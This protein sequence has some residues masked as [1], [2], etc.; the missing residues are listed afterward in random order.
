MYYQTKNPH[1]GD[2]YGEAVE[3]DYSANTN[4]L[5][6]PPAVIAAAA[7]A[8][9]RADRYPDPYCRALVKAIAAAE[10]VPAGSILCGNGA[11]GL[12]FSFCAAAKIRKAAAL[13]PTFSEYA[14]AVKLF[15]GETVLY[16]LCQDRGFLPD[17]DFPDWLR[18][19]R[20]D[21]VFLCNPNNPT[22][23]LLPPALI[24]EVI[25]LCKQI[26][27]RLFVDECFLE[28]ASGGE[29][30]KGCLADFPGLFLLR[31]FTK[32]YGM[33][34]LRLGYC[35][36]ADKALLGRMAALTPPW[37]VSAPAQAAGA[38]ALGEGG[39][40]R[41]AVSLIERERP[42]LRAALEAMG[43]WVCPSDVN[44][45]LFRGPESLLGDLRKKGIALRDCAN[46]PGLGPGWYRMAVR[47]EEEN[48]RLLAAMK[49]C[50]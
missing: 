33:A 19:E 7:E 23:R 6:V 40:L 20:P 45:L 12:I 29:S 28:L 4:P 38:A 16:P 43:L 24:I 21:A 9:T 49:E 15:G 39:F 31:A 2:I 35:L 18:A 50:L 47:T 22:G 41:K 46:F 32:S 3:L 30:L 11:S 17:E 26:N 14:A 48:D 8:L 36:S 25:T 1:G 27:T 10:E 13:A 37:D 42:R 5:G 44:Y 34:G